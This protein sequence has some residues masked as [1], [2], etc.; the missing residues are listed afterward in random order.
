MITL[1]GLRDKGDGSNFFGEFLD[2]T[3]YKPPAPLARDCFPIRRG[4]LSACHPAIYPEEA[5]ISCG[6]ICIFAISKTEIIL[7]SFETKDF[8]PA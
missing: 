7:K 8:S 2:H 5:P 3:D 6:L 4:G 1:I